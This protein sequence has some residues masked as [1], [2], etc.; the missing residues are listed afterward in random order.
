MSYDKDVVWLPV[1][2]NGQEYCSM[3]ELSPSKE[4]RHELFK[5]S[6]PK[7]KYDINFVIN[8]LRI[9]VEQCDK[10]KMTPRD[11]HFSLTQSIKRLIAMLEVERMQ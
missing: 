7:G 3:E 8:M 6:L 5:Y 11:I 2:K 4:E 9:I 10:M 1:T